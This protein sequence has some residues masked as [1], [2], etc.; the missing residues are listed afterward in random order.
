MLNFQFS[1]KNKEQNY[2]WQKPFTFHREPKITGQA[3]IWIHSF[4]LYLREYLVQ[5]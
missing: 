4:F 2:K 5:N 3:K 1:S